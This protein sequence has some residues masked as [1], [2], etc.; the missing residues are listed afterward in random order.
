MCS[1]LRLTVCAVIA[2][3]AVEGTASA[4]DF[5]ILRARY[6]AELSQ[7]V[8]GGSGFRPGSRVEVDGMRLDTVSVSPVEVRAAM[9]AP[10]PATYRVRV[11]GRRGVTR[12]FVLA[13]GGGS[14]QGPAGPV[15]PAGPAGP[16]GF[17]GP[18]GPTG[19]AGTTGPQGLV[20]PAGPSG[21]EGPP[22]PA[23]SPGGLAVIAA[24]GETLG[25]VVGFTPGGPVHV[26]R[27]Q[28]GVWLYAFVTPQDVMPSAFPALYADAN[29]Q[30]PAYTPLDSNPAPFF[31]M[32]QIQNA[33]DPV[34]YFAGNPAAVQS[35]LAYSPL[36]R[37][38]QCWTTAETAWSAPMLAG[39]VQTLDMSRYPA[40][41]AVK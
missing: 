12:S 13:V 35:F 11:V 22:G 34:A 39:P 5:T 17:P 15:G 25:S 1:W 36:G 38:D 6:D 3:V 26:V 23:G 20:G 32:L 2:V 30:T 29:C 18:A 16:A 31:R 10:P 8:I 21:P 14:E 28:K 9:P 33:G 27:E 24:N 4:Q 37:P 41:F 7:I 19:P 40:P